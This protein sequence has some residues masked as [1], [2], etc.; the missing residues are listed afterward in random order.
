M[1]K[2]LIITDSLG[3]PRQK[4]EVVAYD[5]TWI[6]ELAK[7][8]KVHQVSIGGGLISELYTQIEYIKMF[9]PDI[10]IVQ[11]GIVDCAPRAMTKFESIFLNKFWLTRK[12]LKKVLTQKTLAFLRK[13]RNCTYTDIK[14]FEK[15]V[16]DF[17]SVFSGKLYWVEII[18]ASTGYETNVPGITNNV[19]AYNKIIQNHLKQ[20][21]ISL[22]DIEAKHIMTDHIH[23]S[24]EGHAY[25]SN[26][27]KTTL[28]EIKSV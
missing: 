17:S 19:T 25:L 18:P 5:E 3:L 4:P 16:N 28:T 15:Y 27:I 6:N 21:T 11:A 20:N 2:L 14:M 22:E 9:E 13:K 10:V 23:F 12:F 7:Y 26:K 1:K 8:Y 24:K